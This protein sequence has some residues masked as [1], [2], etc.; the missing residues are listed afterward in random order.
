[1]LSQSIWSI[2]NSP[3]SLWMLSSVLLGGI[4]F[5]YTKWGE[6][7]DSK[8]IDAEHAARLAHENLVTTRKL[9]AEIASRL[10]YVH[11]L[12]RLGEVSTKSFL[13]ALASLEQPST[14]TY[15]V[16]VFPEYSQR[17]LRSLLWELL[18][19]LPETSQAEKDEKQRVR[20]AYDRAKLFP[21][22]YALAQRNR[23]TKV[24]P[25]ARANLN[26][27]K[28]KFFNLDRWENPFTWERS[29]KR[30]RLPKDESQHIADSAEGG[31]QEL[32]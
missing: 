21:T 20:V 8:R 15:S 19:V 24:D 31:E 1:M 12:T 29:G 3:F 14:E 9:D 11:S 6:I 27:V 5:A 16:S 2:L 25:A 7:R 4:T 18:Q 23:T 13:L 30:L 26:S 17:T 10:S 22:I 28:I 32:Q